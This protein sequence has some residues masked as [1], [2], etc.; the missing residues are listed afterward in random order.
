MNSQQQISQENSYGSFRQLYK[1]VQSINASD[2]RSDCMSIVIGHDFGIKDSSSDFGK[3]DSGQARNDKL[4]DLPLP[5]N[6]KHHST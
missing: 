3:F 5:L 6:K 2:D 1:Q 4:G